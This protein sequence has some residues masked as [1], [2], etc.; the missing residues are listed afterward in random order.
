MPEHVRTFLRTQWPWLAGLGV[1]V[2]LLVALVGLYLASGAPETGTPIAAQ[3]SATP[4]PI[5]LTATS[6]AQEQATFAA[7]QTAAA[8]TVTFPSATL[9]AT[10]TLSLPPTSG[11]YPPP[12]PSLEPTIAGYPP[13]GVGSPLPSLVPTSGGYPPPGASPAAPATPF[14]GTPPYPGP[15]QEATPSPSPAGSLG[16]T[17]TLTATPTFLVSPSP[18]PIGTVVLPTSTQVLLLPCNF[19]E[20]VADKSYPPGSLVY[21]GQIFTKIWTV[22]NGGT[23][24]WTT[25]YDLV[26]DSGDDMRTHPYY[27]LRST[28]APNTFVDLSINFT[29]PS[30]PGIAKA[31]WLLRNDKNEPFGFWEAGNYDQPLEVK[32][33]VREPDPSMTQDMVNDNCVADW[34][35]RLGKILCLGDPTFSAGSVVV[36]QRPLLETDRLED[37]PTLWT[38]PGTATGAFIS[39]VFPPYVVQ[40]GDH[41]QSDVGCLANSPDCDITF[42]VG[43]REGTSTLEHT[44][45]TFPETEDGSITRID[46]D[47][48]SLVGKEI[49]LVLTVRAVSHPDQ[50]D[51]FWL[52]PGI[53]NLPP[54]P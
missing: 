49:R 19:G 39:G 51:A 36:L 20:F 50:A 27:P 33:R 15:E 32:V 43:Y 23:C 25:S 8:Q 30:L 44:L 52:A 48:S 24:A 22:R 2:A 13:P 46:L 9:T 1:L 3:V 7:R 17:A 6:A 18:T 28:V 4:S 53:R 41:F 54:A 11:A 38:R 47:L 31:W 42:T 40:E 16:P 35:A 14:Q 10:P 12:L 5:N 34:R 29:A 45:D 37:Q 21:P 26:Y